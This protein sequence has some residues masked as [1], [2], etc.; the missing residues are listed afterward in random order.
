MNSSSRSRP[1][2]EPPEPEGG[3]VASF[4]RSRSGGS[5][6]TVKTYASRLGRYVEWHGGE[7][8]D[9]ESYDSYIAKIKREG[10]RPNGIAL[11]ARVLLLYADHLEVSTKG[12]QRVKMHDVVT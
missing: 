5:V 2:T 1:A 12:W 9:R 6:E 3:P 8:I 7:G 4:L 10:R 11:D